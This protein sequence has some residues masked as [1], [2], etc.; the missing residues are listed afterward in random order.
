[1]KLKRPELL[2]LAVTALALVFTAGFFTGRGTGGRVITV[3]PLT[4]SAP[5]SAPP[6]P[7]IEGA[8]GDISYGLLPAA[9][10]ADGG[11]E[12]AEPAQAA[13]TP[14]PGG[15]A[16]A[17]PESPHAAAPA[18]AD[19]VPAETTATPDSGGTVVKV[20][21]E[22]R[23]NLN[24]ASTTELCDLP[25]IG[26]VLSERIIEYRREHGGF[27]SISEIKNVSGIGNAKYAAIKDLI[28][29]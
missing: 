26:A 7:V 2:M 3:T 9:G 28:T 5:L 25:G 14:D 22:N 17:A 8:D 10:T 18:A 23:I 6:A 13:E 29:V 16:A 11:A 4:H 24:T 20:S 27:S 15:E 12:A 1:M 21:S 19:P